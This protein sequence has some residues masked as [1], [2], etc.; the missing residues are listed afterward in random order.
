MRPRGF[1]CV[2]RRRRALLAT[3]AALFVLLFVSLCAQPAAAIVTPDD[4][5]AVTSPAIPTDETSSQSVKTPTNKRPA[6]KSSSTA[7]R[8]VASGGAGDVSLAEKQQEAL[9]SSESPSTA[10][11]AK[12]TTGEADASTATKPQRVTEIYV[13]E[14]RGLAWSM[15]VR[16]SA[17]Q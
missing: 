4:N 7:S 12:V 1:R 14:V 9:R 13:D 2:R 16:L 3:S 6:A 5:K 11:D 10:G 17:G 8:D 15:V